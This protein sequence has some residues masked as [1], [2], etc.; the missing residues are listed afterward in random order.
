MEITFV[1]SSDSHSPRSSRN[2]SIAGLIDS[3]II[4]LDLARTTTSSANLT[5]NRFV[6]SQPLVTFPLG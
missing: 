3:S 5:V 2:L 1:F 6:D 4:L